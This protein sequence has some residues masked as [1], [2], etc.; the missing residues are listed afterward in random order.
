MFSPPHLT[1]ASSIPDE[2]GN[3]EIASFYLNAVSCFVNKY[4]KH[5]QIIR[6]SQKT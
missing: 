6:W 5:I 2:T 3:P 4:I 1:T